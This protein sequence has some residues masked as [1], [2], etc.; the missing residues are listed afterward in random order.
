[1][2]RHSDGVS[3]GEQCL[4]MPHIEL[5]GSARLHTERLNSILPSPIPF[6]DVIEE[7]GYGKDYV[8]YIRSSKEKNLLKVLAGFAL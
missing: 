4:E 6:N 2:T 8:T 3:F 1:M 5:L 7:L